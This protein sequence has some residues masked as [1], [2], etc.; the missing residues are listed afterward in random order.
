MERA[1]SCQ[2]GDPR[3]KSQSW[4]ITARGASTQCS[5][6]ELPRQEREARL[7]IA[8]PDSLALNLE[9][10]HRREELRF[11]LGDPQVWRLTK[12]LTGL[13]ELPGCKGSHPH[14]CPK[15]TGASQSPLLRCRLPKSR[16]LPRC[17]PSPRA[18]LVLHTA[19]SWPQLRHLTQHRSASSFDTFPCSS[20][21][22]GAARTLSVLRRDTGLGC[23]AQRSLSRGEAAPCSG[24]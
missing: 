3:G 6:P 15:G 11:L 8:L 9:A 1:G 10:L 21:P 24:D 14:C 22:K 18:T 12:L 19:G 17:Q 4:P 2:L 13:P 5:V 16:A 7:Q 23:A 20:G